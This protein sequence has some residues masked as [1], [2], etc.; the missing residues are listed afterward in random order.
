MYALWQLKPGVRSLE[1][2]EHAATN[3]WASPGVIMD[4]NVIC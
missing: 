4:L 1:Y 3:D 2:G